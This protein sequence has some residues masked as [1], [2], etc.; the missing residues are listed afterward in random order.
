MISQLKDQSEVLFDFM[1]MNNPYPAARVCKQGSKIFQP[2]HL[3]GDEMGQ[4]ENRLLVN[5][6]SFEMDLRQHALMV[7]NN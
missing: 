1:T 6:A 4:L 3:M 5:E 2:D 7:F